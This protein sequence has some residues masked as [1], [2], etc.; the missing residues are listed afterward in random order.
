MQA[1]TDTGVSTGGGLDDWSNLAKIIYR[2]TYSRNDFEQE[3]WEQT[4]RR[5]INGNIEKYRG[6]EF[7]EPNEEE[8]LFYYLSKRKA[9]PAGRGLWFSGTDAHKR[10]GG[11]GLSN[12]FFFSADTVD[13]F[14]NSMDCL[15]L[16]GGVGFSVEK[17]FLDKLPNLIKG[18][19]IN[20]INTADTT[21][22]FKVEDSREGWCALIEKVLKSVFYTGENFNYTTYY[23]RKKG[24]PIVGFGGKASGADPLIALVEKILAIVEQQGNRLSS[25]G[26]VDI[27]CAIGEMVVSG[28]VRRSAI[29]I[30]GDCFD[31]DYLKAKRWDLGNIPN[32][33]AMANFSVVCSDAKDLTEAFWATYE[34]GEPFGIFNRENAQKYARI[35]EYKADTG[36]G[37]NPCGEIVLESGE[38][39][40][41]QEIFMSNLSSEA[42]FH[43]AARL[44]HRW[45]KRVACEDYHQDLTDNVVKRNRRLGTGITGCLQSNLM[46][47]DILDRVYQTIQKENISYSNQLGIPVSIRTTTVKPSGTLSLVGDCTPGIH[48][49]FSKYY[50]RRVRLA[51]NDAL[52][53]VLLDAGHPVE[54]VEKF[55]GTLD[56]TTVV[57]SFFCKVPNG[58]PCA[59]ENFDTWKQLEML[60]MA[61]KYWSDNSV[62]VT[63]YYKKEEI[64]DIKRWLAKNLSEIKTISFL[65]YSEHGF[66]QAPYEKITKEEY[67]FMT[68]HISPIDLSQISVEEL[69]SMECSSGAC[70]IR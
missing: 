11:I 69:E 46:K 58:T 60:K 38:G 40:N 42:E 26:A 54:F 36:E 68:E 45:G 39:C 8:R 1:I 31:Q 16:G 53:N 57:A 64:E 13:N 50:I 15:M 62:S 3:I 70:P 35:G 65:C 18:V 49:A 30:L 20:H 10:L 32:Q 7:L 34:A 4:V 55:D 51:S 21:E 61:Q 56:D 22:T 19:K 5:V 14:V 12:C 28:N 24:Q 43:E 37:L 67:D 66:K 9:M 23:V 52:V 59:D 41:L 17:K 44:M 25:L 2:R 47:E 63:V 29:I 6:T 33:R 48:P 27:E